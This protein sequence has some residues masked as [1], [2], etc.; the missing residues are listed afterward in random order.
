[1][2]LCALSLGASQFQNQDEVAVPSRA[3]E[4]VVSI[5]AES[6]RHSIE[7]TVL[8]YNIAALPWP[9]KE[10]TDRRLRLT[11]QELSEWQ[12]SGSAPDI[13][14]FQEAFTPESQSMIQNIGYQYTL[15]GP[16][17]ETSV[18]LYIAPE[19]TCVSDQS[20]LKGEGLRPVYGG[21]LAIVSRY[22][23]SEPTA[24]PFGSH[25]C[26]G[27]D[28]LAN[29]GIAQAKV[30]IPGLPSPLQVATTHLN[31]KRSS[32]VSDTRSAYAHQ[33]QLLELRA[34][35]E[36]WSKDN[37]PVVAGGDL[38]VHDS[39]VRA[40]N[41]LDVLTDTEYQLSRISCAYDEQCRSLGLAWED[42]QDHHLY[43][44]SDNLHIAPIEEREIFVDPIDGQLLSDHNGYL[45]RYRI[46]W[47]PSR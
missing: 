22:P 24:T 30:I 4:V 26:A 10:N 20:I 45:V 39:W 2:A 11:R 17:E 34:R 28:C 46:S 21:G 1:M 47:L 36:S 18:Q 25:K 3:K 38:N 13:I 12:L 5:D 31:S 7:L 37:M 8:T 15:W 41:L 40:G 43:R 44:S 6:E 33:L 27:Y 19:E 16:D 32:G 35:F 29:K 14:L 42:Q 9:L 23:L